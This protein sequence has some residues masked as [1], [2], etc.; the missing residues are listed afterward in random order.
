[1]EVL[2]WGHFRCFSLSLQLAII[3]ALDIQQ[4][5]RALAHARNSVTHFHHYPRSRNLLK[6]KQSDLK[7]PSHSLVQQVPTRWNSAYYMVQRV[8]EQQQPL[9]ATLLELQRPDLLPTDAEITAMEVFV[10]VMKPFVQITEIMGAETWVTSS[11]VRP[12]LYKLLYNHLSA[13]SADSRLKK[14]VKS[15]ILEKLQVCY[16]SPVSLAPLLEK[17]S[18]LDHRFK[19][20]NLLS[21]AERNAT[22]QSVEEDLTSDLVT[23][24]SGCGSTASSDSDLTMGPLPKKGKL[25][26]L[27]SDVLSTDAAEED[28]LPIDTAEMAHREVANY[29]ALVPAQDY[30]PLEWWRENC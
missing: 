19:G 10:E 3:R 12:L 30:N 15:A 7:H 9:C 6:E 29:V 28:V 21:L 20:Q 18:C 17:S 8:L 24:D 13:S 1:M 2:G 16:V 27:L 5:S 25:M 26:T 23:L 22:V 11:A 14:E 4:V